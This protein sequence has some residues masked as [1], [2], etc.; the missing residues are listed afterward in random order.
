MFRVGPSE[1]SFVVMGDK[2]KNNCCSCQEHQIR[3]IALKLGFV[4]VIALGLLGCGLIERF[5][6]FRERVIE[7]AEGDSILQKVSTTFNKEILFRSSKNGTRFSVYVNPG[8]PKISSQRYVYN[9]GS[10][11]FIPSWSFQFWKLHLLKGSTLDIKI[12]ADQYVMFYII[13]GERYYTEWA[14]STLFDQYHFKHRVLPQKNCRDKASFK[15]HNL[16]AR[17]TDFFYIMFS[18]SVGWRFFTHVSIMMQF[19]RTMYN[20]TM[21]S[22]E[23]HSD[24]SASNACVA[25]LKYNSHEISLIE[26]NAAKGEAPDAFKKHKIISQPRSRMF[27]Y[28]AFYCGIFASVLL[29]TLLYTMWRCVVQNGRVKTDKFPL[30]SVS[31]R[32]YSDSRGSTIKPKQRRSTRATLGS[33]EVVSNNEIDMEREEEQ[34]EEEHVPI[35]DTNAGSIYLTSDQVRDLSLTAAGISA[36]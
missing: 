1:T 21:A 28:I 34:D 36:I 9:S 26:F 27:Y 5:Q 32:I 25:S 30:L 33:F 19:N 6:V 2:T 17:E 4:L 15:S 35:N 22:Q 18:S 16:K 11:F 24:D 13:K 23:C 7:G 20:T 31:K 3:P 8:V 10:T 29:L 14:E 12:C